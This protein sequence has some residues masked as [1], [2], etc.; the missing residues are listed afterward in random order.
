MFSLT[1]HQ[2]LWRHPFRPPQPSLSAHKRPAI[3]RLLRLLWEHDPATAAHSLRVCRYALRLGKALS[4][5][6]RQRRDLS[7]A[8]HLHDI[9]KLAVPRDILQKPARLTPAEYR[10]LR[11]HPA[12]GERI[13]AR[14]APS[15]TVLAAIRGHHERFDGSGYPDGLH[16]ENIPLLARILAIADSFDAMT[17]SRTYRA[18]LPGVSALAIIHLAAGTQFDP[19]LVKVFSAI[20]TPCFAC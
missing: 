15:P 2:R 8:A 10:Q 18:A 4:L 1:L 9:G 14:F 20:S 3:N 11:E 5:D 17:R 19:K 12:K 6:S 16:G 7:M 13:I